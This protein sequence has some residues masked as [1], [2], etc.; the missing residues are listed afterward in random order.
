[1]T[2]FVLMPIANEHL[3][4]LG[5]TSFENQMN[6]AQQQTPGIL[7]FNTGPSHFGLELGSSWFECE[8]DSKFGFLSKIPKC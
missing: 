4:F 2:D 3:K 6:C 8:S 5:Q 7:K 1:M